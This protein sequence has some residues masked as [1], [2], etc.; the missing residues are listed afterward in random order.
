MNDWAATCADSAVRTSHSSDG[1]RV[2]S[3]EREVSNLNTL[4]MNAVRR[5]GTLCINTITGA[6]FPLTRH[7]LLLRTVWWVYF[8]I[9]SCVDVIYATGGGEWKVR[10]G[11][12][13]DDSP[14][15]RPVSPLFLWLHTEK[16]LF[17]F[18]SALLLYYTV[19]ANG[20]YIL[21]F[22]LF[23]S[24]WLLSAFTQHSLMHD[25]QLVPNFSPPSPC[26]SKAHYPD[27]KLSFGTKVSKSVS[28]RLVSL[29]VLW[30]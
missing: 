1:G 14:N 5:V 6:S 20:E 2:N 22:Y 12:D 10:G 11:G 21:S 26:R 25:Q 9:I 19:V 3:R 27:I 24:E 29:W 8:S 7:A 4:F 16:C 17:I 13:V 15:F 28:A 18:V 23:D 30:S